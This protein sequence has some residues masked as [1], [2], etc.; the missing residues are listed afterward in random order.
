M[1]LFWSI[2]ILSFAGSVIPM[3]FVV[4]R[5]LKKAGYKPG[6]FESW[7]GAAA[8]PKWA[9]EYLKIRKRYGWSAWPV[10]LV[11]IMVFVGIGLVLFGLKWNRG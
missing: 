10:H 4:L 11:W 7:S 3:Y 5:R 8:F 6:R 2:G 1:D 9:R